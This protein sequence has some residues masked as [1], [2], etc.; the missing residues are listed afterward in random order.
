MLLSYNI[1]IMTNLDIATA[2]SNGLFDNA[3][4]FIDQ[5]ASWTIVEENTF[6]GKNAI[7]ENCKNVS[8]YFKSV[9]TEFR[10]LNSITEDNKIA[11]NGTAKFYRNGELVSSVSSCD[12]Y[13]FND[14][15]KI[16]T[17]TSYCLVG[18]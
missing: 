7:I 1:R 11:I 9:V 8:R 13:I 4:N 3:Y 16:Q 5:D 17:I 15:N 14:K 2:F 6:S 10:I 18:K 12:V